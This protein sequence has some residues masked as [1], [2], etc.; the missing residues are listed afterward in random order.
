MNRLALKVAWL[1]MWNTA[2]TAAIS[3]FRPNS[4]VIR[5]RWLM[6]EYAS[7]P[8]RSCWNRAAKAPHSK[9]SM[10]ARDTSS[11][12]KSVPASAGYSRAI[13]NTPALTMVA[14]CK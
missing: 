2:A 4:R 8:L 3:L 11:N 9:V 7:N 6:V 5:P 14:E 12:H 13:R 1:M 10:P